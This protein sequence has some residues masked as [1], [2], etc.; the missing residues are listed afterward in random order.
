MPGAMMHHR[1]HRPGRALV[2]E[3]P[4]REPDRPEHQAAQPG[5]PACPMARLPD[6]N[7]LRLS[8]HHSTLPVMS[9]R[10]FLNQRF[11][12]A[13]RV[14]VAPAAVAAAAAAEV[15]AVPA[16]VVAVAAAEV[17]A[18]PA[19]VVAVAAPAAVVADSAGTET[20]ET[21]MAVVQAMETAI[22]GT[23]L[24]ATMDRIVHRCTI[25]H[26]GQIVTATLEAS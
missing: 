25:S 9:A 4:A 5:E 22:T 6:P 16:A 18:T 15:V 8:N 17:V 24:A 19:A 11:R 3:P 10:S 20:A 26:G 7:F 21:G 1:M 13:C 2:E 12:L 23:A 14:R